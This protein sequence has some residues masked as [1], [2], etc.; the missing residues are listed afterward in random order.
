MIE[1]GAFAACEYIIV[2]TDF[3]S[4]NAGI[5]PFLAQVS[6]YDSIKKKFIFCKS[7]A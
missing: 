7:I 6:L 2:T 5:F 4:G 3:F 1:N